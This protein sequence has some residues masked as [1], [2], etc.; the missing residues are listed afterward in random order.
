MTQLA[1]CIPLD[2]AMQDVLPLVTALTE[3]SAADIEIVIAR[4]VDMVMSE[5][6]LSLATGDAR[7]R[8]IDAEAGISPQALWREAVAATTGNWVTL[9][10]PGDMIE[11]DLAVM[12]AYLETHSPDVDALAWNAF[13][14]DRH[15]ER[16]KTSSVA[17]PAGYQIETLDKTAMLKAFFCWENSL[18]VPKMP[19]GL[20]HAAI[21]RSL[22]DAL[23]ELPEMRDW[24]TPLPQYEWAA[25]VALFANELAF[26]ARPMSAISTSP[27]MAETPRHE[28]NFPF[29]SGLGLAGAVAEVQ[30]HVL[31]ELGSPWSGNTEAFVRALTI[32]CMM[33]TS[34]EAFMAKGNAYFAALREFEGGHLAPHFRPEFR[35]VRSQDTRR[36]LHGKAL[37]VDR[38]LGGAQDAGEFYDTV[39]LMLAPIGLICGGVVRDGEKVIA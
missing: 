30:F 26:C 9:V 4:P 33:E 15:A 12:V 24:S 1:I 34:R 35:E 32:E 17:I 11:S 31:R 10:K 14:I 27:Y 7:V 39:R 6:L 36:G 29:H 37:L 16:G 20:Y 23:R 3:N 8:V 22:V 2:A 28:W 13:Q 18:S 19:F 25:R 5:A 21:R 38:F